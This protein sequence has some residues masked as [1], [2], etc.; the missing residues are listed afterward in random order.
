MDDDEVP[1]EESYYD[2]VWR[3]REMQCNK[4]VSKLSYRAALRLVCS[5]A[6]HTT[7]TKSVAYSA[8]GEFCT[9]GSSNLYIFF[10]L[11]YPSNAACVN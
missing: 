11:V 9:D 4:P 3:L 6:E 5:S 8:T 10:L 7:C 2:P 1:Q